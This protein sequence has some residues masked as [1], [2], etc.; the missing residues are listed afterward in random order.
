MPRFTL[1]TD[2]KKQLAPSTEKRYKT[3]LNKLVPFG[4]TNRD[5]I[6]ARQD[7][8]V[9]AVNTL[10]PNDDDEARQ[11]KRTFYSAIFWVCPDLPP[12]NTLRTAFHQA[13]QNYGR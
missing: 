12:V 6:L 7:E 10:V 8:A 1:P 2:M 4:F 11:D 5:D 13:K 9:A 3:H